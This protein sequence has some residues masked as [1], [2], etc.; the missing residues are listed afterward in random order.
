MRDLDYFNYLRKRSILGL[1]YRKYYLYPVLQKQLKGNVLDLGC[2]VGDY[3]KFNRDAIGVD[4]NKE[5][6]KYLNSINVKAVFMQ[7]DILPFCDESFS[8][9]IMDNVLEH[10]ENPDKILKEIQRVLKPNGLFLVGVPGEKG[11]K[12]DSDH[13]VFYDEKKL[14]S[15]MID[16][17]FNFVKTLVMPIKL[18][19]LSKYLKIFCLYSVFYK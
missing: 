13:K 6:I 1:I 8:S 16:N 7:K 3:L 15:L 17:K 5:N 18:S 2:G 19:F 4:V 14:K 11:F 12:S 9:I 10:I